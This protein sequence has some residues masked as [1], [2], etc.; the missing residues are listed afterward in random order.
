MTAK[1]TKD[2]KAE[3]SGG[4]WMHRVYPVPSPSVTA[5]LF[6]HADLTLCF[7]RGREVGHA[8]GYQTGRNAGYEDGREKG[9]EESQ[10]Y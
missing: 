5:S 6:T 8:S 10:G 1:M 2:E 9:H 7:E 4:T 3:W